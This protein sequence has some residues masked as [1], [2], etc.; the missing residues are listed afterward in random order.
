MTV[1][2]I[3]P[4]V[5]RVSRTE[6]AYI[7]LREALLSGVFAPGAQ[8]READVAEQL[9]VSKTPVREAMSSLRAK[10]LLV[11]G[12]KRGIL[13][14]RIDAETVR[15][16]H[17]VRAVLEPEAFRLAVPYLDSDLVRL[18][19][20]HLD[21]AARHGSCHDLGAMSRANRDFHELLYERCPNNTMKFLLNDMRDQ[22]QFAAVSG[23]RG[24]ASSWEYEREEHIAMLEAAARGDGELAAQLCKQH[25]ERAAV[26]ILAAA[27]V[28]EEPRSEML[29]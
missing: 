21:E 24:T 9:N 20:E 8:L 27:A 6:Q 22:L 4:L 28:A 13:V 5:D 17:E 19:H 12:P 10:G 16:I 26:K 25:I 1:A 2:R 7:A 18:A 15:E 23:W 3:E 29:R 14:A 11:P